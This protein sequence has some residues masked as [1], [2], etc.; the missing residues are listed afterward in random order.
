[1]RPVFISHSGLWSA[2]GST[3]EAVRETLLQRSPTGGRLGVLQLSFPYAFAT[4][5]LKPFQ[6]RLEEG[7]QAVSASLDLANL[8][9]EAPLLLGSSS[10]QIGMVEEG[11]WP[12]PQ[13]HVLPQDHLD[14]SIRTFLGLPNTG[15]TFSSAC[16]S[17]V[18][19]LDAAIGLIETGAAEEALVVGVEILNR[20]TLSGFASLQLLSPTASR[21]LDLH[22]DGLM[23]GEAIAAV[24]LSAQPSPWR[25]HAPALA[26]DASSATGHATDGSTLAD[27][28]GR[29]LVYAETDPKSLRAIKLQASGSP[30]ADA[31]EARALRRVFGEQ[32]PPVLSLKA[33][34]GHTL[35]AS[36]LAEMVALL[37]AGYL[38]P[39]AGFAEPDPE[40]GVEPLE[41]PLAWDS[42][43]IL[44]NIQG[45]GGGLA[46]W[47][48]ERR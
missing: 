29:A 16:T 45:F 44:L 8:A 15:W 39:T 22:R 23:L 3:P 19:A 20:T 47:V 24:R 14:E 46:S 38:P 2:A 18:Q 10:L 36:G 32:L 31:V 42:G 17:A 27:V 25:V 33:A 40:L 34:L 26:L 4:E 11:A 5:P 7:L 30:G 13:G 35:G 1:M 41:A 43:P 9:A 28:M 21:P 6:A 48:L 37:Q 12:P